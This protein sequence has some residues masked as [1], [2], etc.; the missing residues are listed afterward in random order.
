MNLLK[1]PL[2]S[3]RWTSSTSNALDKVVENDDKDEG[4][5]MKAAKGDGLVD[6]HEEDRVQ[7]FGKSAVRLEMKGLRAI[8]KPSFSWLLSYFDVRVPR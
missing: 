6:K 4:Q 1:R 8:A 7:N 2:T 5:Q 3:T